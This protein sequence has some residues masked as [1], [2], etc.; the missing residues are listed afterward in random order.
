MASVVMADA[1]SK[2]RIR[3]ETF[4]RPFHEASLVNKVV[5]PVAECVGHV[6]FF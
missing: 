5:C 6:L 2:E 4:L 3:A 1:I